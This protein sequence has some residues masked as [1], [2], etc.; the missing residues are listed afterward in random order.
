MNSIRAEHPNYLGEIYKVEIDS[1]N[2]QDS[3]IKFC[4]EWNR[5]VE[6]APHLIIDTTLTGKN[7]ELVQIMSPKLG[8]PTVIMRARETNYFKPKTNESKDDEN[9]NIINII[10]PIDLMP[11]VIRQLVEDLD[12][13]LDV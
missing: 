13:R 3:V 8:I 11:E 9:P 12:F 5:S 10:P 1:L 7:A 6:N 2:P 4:S